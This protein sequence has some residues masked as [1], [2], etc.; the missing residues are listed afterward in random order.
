MTGYSFTTPVWEGGQWVAPAVA[1]VTVKAARI[2]NGPEDQPRDTPVQ[3]HKIDWR[4]QEEQVR[5][6]RQ[7]IFKAAQEQDWPQ[8]RN[9]QKLMLRSRANTLVSVRQV[10]QRNTGRKTAGID[11]EVAL[12]PEARAAVAVRVHQSIS[13][14]NPRAVRRVYIPKPSNRAKLRPLGIPVL[15]DRCHQQRV[16][17]AL[18]PE[19]EARFEPRSYGFRPG[20]SCQ[21]AIAAIFITCAGPRAKRVW[22]LDADLAAAFDKI[23]HSFLLSQLG[24]FPAREMIAGWLKA[25]VFEA[26]KGFAPTEEGTPQGGPISPC[27]LNVA[28]HGLEEAAGVCYRTSG[29]RAGEVMPGSPVAIRYADDVVVLCHSQEQAGQVKARLAE[30]LAPRGLAF[31]EDKTKIVHLSEGFDTLGFNVRRYNRKLLI[32][33]SRAAVRRLRE[34]LAAEMRTLRGG[35]AM[36]VIAKLNPIIRG[37]AAYYRGVV[38]SRLFRWLD[39]YLWKLLY[40]WARWRHSNKPKFWI[41]GRYFGKF[42]KFRNDHWVFGDRDTGAY[43]VKFSWTAIERHV[44]VKGAA[45]PDDPALTAYWA[46]RREKVKPPLDRY[47]LRLLTS[48]HGLCPLC[49][50]YL[51]SADQP[52]QSPQQWETWWLSVTR[53][54]IAAS[55]LTHHG[56]PG[57]PSDDQTRLV[58]ASCQ[59]ASQARQRRNPELQPATP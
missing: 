56:Q 39:S 22:A 16:R 13:S 7:R 37:W 21:D 40:K 8:V 12:T 54:A 50:D 38:S 18:E 33:P 23:G 32:K 25:G 35:N 19:W 45:S 3:W 46:K 14:W 59:R 57:T 48:Q 11:G 20:R 29:T 47:T 31:N 15:M 10:T 51:L 52:P 58:H 26:G 36:A 53:K 6:L 34:R 41:V 1:E 9:L 44:P 55:Y 49:G 28:L 27:L 2:A 43:L 4:A 17:H 24:S 42:N 30:W 5:R